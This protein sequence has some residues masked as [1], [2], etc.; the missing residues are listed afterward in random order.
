MKKLFLVAA[1]VAVLS[2]QQRPAAM[3]N[4][5]MQFWS[6]SD[7]FAPDSPGTEKT[8]PPAPIGVSGANC[9]VLPFYGGW[10]QTQDTIYACL[11]FVTLAAGPANTSYL[12]RYNFLVNVFGPCNPNSIGVYPDSSCTYPVT[13]G[14][15]YT[16]FCSGGVQVTWQSFTTSATNPQSGSIEP[17]FVITAVAY[18]PIL[19]GEVMTGTQLTFWNGYSTLACNPKSCTASCS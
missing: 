4:H 18:S 15:T 2:A 10:T 9:K 1:S 11:P 5:Y 6:H 8:H 3:P 12:A 13:N 14:F 17:A 16:S 19:E 7:A